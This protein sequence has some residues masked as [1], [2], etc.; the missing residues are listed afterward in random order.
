M[1]SNHTIIE[2]K[3]GLMISEKQPLFSDSIDTPRKI[4]M[5]D[6]KLRNTTNPK[7]MENE[8]KIDSRSFSQK[9]CKFYI[10]S[11]VV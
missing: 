1:K 4:K 10:I 2:S 5:L 7:L 8:R 6:R 11:Y 9:F 3:E